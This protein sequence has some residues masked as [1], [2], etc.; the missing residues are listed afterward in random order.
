MVPELRNIRWLIQPRLL[1]N[2]T[3]AVGTMAPFNLPLQLALCC[4]APAAQAVELQ[5]ALSI[6]NGSGA[7]DTEAAAETA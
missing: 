3:L 2:E 1:H 5:A 4:Q 6:V 7:W